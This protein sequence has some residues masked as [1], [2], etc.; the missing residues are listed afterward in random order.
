MHNKVSVVIVQLLLS[1]PGWDDH[2]TQIIRLDCPWWEASRRVV[3][4]TNKP[5]FC[6]VFFVICPALRRTHCNIPIFLQLS[7]DCH[8]SAVYHKCTVKVNSL[9][10][11]YCYMITHMTLST[12][13]RTTVSLSLWINTKTIKKSYLLFIWACR[14]ELAGFFWYFAV[15]GTG[16]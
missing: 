12:E 14:E 7:H 9:I 2:V 1:Q 3:C 6:V 8:A 5:T 16:F 10:N 15:F 11:M 4:T 13:N